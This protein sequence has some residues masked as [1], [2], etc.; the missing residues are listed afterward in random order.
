MGGPALP[1]PAPPHPHQNLVLKTFEVTLLEKR[2]RN[3]LKCLKIRLLGPRV[4]A[5]D[6]PPASHPVRFT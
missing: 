1:G 3:V 2:V 6:D 5:P 4:Q